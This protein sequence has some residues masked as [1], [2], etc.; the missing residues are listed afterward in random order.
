MLLTATAVGAAGQYFDGWPLWLFVGPGDWQAEGTAPLHQFS[1]IV[2]HD[3]LGNGVS[4][5]NVESGVAEKCRQK[6]AIDLA[7]DREREPAMIARR[8]QTT[9]AEPG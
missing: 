2:E 4:I 7:D 3:G 1:R 6:F 8:Q 9:A 5:V